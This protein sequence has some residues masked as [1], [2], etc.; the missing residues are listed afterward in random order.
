MNV[1]PFALELAV[2]VVL[3]LAVAAWTLS[4]VLRAGEGGAEPIIRARAKELQKGVVSA[5]HA[6]RQPRP[7]G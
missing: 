4:F 3:I 2:A 7:T 1:S 5:R 6:D